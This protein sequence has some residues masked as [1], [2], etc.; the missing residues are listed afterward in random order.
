MARPRTRCH[1]GH[2]NLRQLPD[3]YRSR[4]PDVAVR[5]WSISIEESLAQRVEG[6]IGSRGLS[7]YVAQALQNELDRD[8][9]R[10][11]VREYLD[12][13]DEEFGPLSEEEI[14]AARA[15]WPF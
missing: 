2:V 15:E 14:E 4:I 5:K 11:R 3:S 13:L 8:D 6:R 1:D 10:R 9:E 7:A 12:E